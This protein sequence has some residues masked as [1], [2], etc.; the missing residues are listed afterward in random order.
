M[1]T[2]PYVYRWENNPTDA[3]FKGKICRLVCRGALNTVMLE[4]EDGT[5]V[6]TSGD[7]IRKRGSTS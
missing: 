3:K 7:A 1:E 5:R 2:Y 6:A 4:F